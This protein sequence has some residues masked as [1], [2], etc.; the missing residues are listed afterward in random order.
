MKKFLRNLRYDW[1]LHFVL[2]LANWLPD[3]V[4]CLRIR[5]WLA[6]SFL[7]KCG[8]NFRLGRNV[9]FY[10]PQYISLG[11]DVYIAQGCVFLA[12]ERIRLDDEVMFGPYV[13]CAAGNHLQRNGSFRFGGSERMP[14]SIGRGTWVAAHVTILAGATIGNGCLVAANAAVPA[15]TYPNYALIGG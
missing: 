8:K 2:C 7:G 6:R 12:T 10:N 9:T 13:V 3:N 11:N 15:G 5:G 4:L 14:I 1:P